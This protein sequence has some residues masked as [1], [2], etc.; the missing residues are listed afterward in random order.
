MPVD[1]AAVVARLRELDA[2][3]GGRRVAWTATWAQER[4]RLR[5]WLEAEAP[6]VRIER[7]AAGNVWARLDGESPQTV[8]VGS[9]LDCVPDGGWLDGCLGVLAGAAVL[10]DVARAGRPRRSLA[11]VDFADEEGARFGHSLLGSS[12]AAGLLDVDAAAKL[13][14]ADGVTLP[15]ALAEHGVALDRMPEARR[16]LEGAAAY[17]EL[18]IEQGPVLD[19]AEEPAAAVAGCMGVRRSSLTVTGRAGHAGATPMALRRDP[20]QAAAAFVRGIRR[21]AEEAGGV[22]TV[23]ALHT[24]PA[25]PTA[26]PARVRLTLDL[27]HADLAALQALDARARELA[28]RSAHDEHCTAERAPLW[29]IDPVPFDPALVARARE[30]TGGRE[31]LTSGPLHDAAAV[32]RAGVPAVMVFARTLGG[33]S[34]S[35]EEDAREQDLFVAID[36]FAALVSELLAG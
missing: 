7:D 21:A 29:A 5:A 28:T 2:R 13:A 19:E 16:A 23:G 27:R 8:V 24:E 26:I 17:V 4:E 3:S 6:G 15:A 11:L 12:A 1:A 33:V 35:R 9:H 22:A 18:H 36:A 14:D 34:H 30:L 20:L 10:A 25:T 31:A 32:A